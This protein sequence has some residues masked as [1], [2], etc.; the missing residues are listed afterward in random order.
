MPIDGAILKGKGMK[1]AKVLRENEF[2][3]SDCWLSE[4]K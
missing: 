3:A 2:K 1:F 4:K